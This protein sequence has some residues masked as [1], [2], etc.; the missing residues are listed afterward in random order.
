MDLNRVSA[1]HDRAPWFLE[2]LADVLA[3]TLGRHGHATLLTVHGWNVVQPAIDLGLGCAPGTDPFSVGP[4]AAVSPAFAAVAVRALVGACAGHRIAAT[5]GARYPARAREN[6]LQLFT[7]R[8]AGDGRSRVAALASMASAVDAVQLELGIPLR[9]PGPWR[10]RFVEACR[11]AL[12]SLTAGDG[13]VAGGE[14]ATGRPANALV[15]CRLQFAGVPFSGLA[16]LG[17]DGGA[18]LL[19]LPHDGGLLLFTG[20][21]A[22]GLAVA[23]T[24]PGAV[25]L[26]YA[27]PLLRF[28]DTRPFLDLERG[29]AAGR[30]VD[31]EVRMT[32][33]PAHAGSEAGEFGSVAGTVA[34]DGR[35]VELSATAFAED[36]ER[37]GPWPRLRAALQL[38]RTTALSLTLGLAGQEV[39][40]FLCRAG[41]HVGVTAARASLGPP[42]APLE[43]VTLEVEVA[44]GER[45]CVE[46][47][48]VHELPVVRSRGPAAVRVVF[49]ACAVDGSRMPVGWCE[50][51]GI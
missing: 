22:G 37:P 15:P 12:P 20:E 5:V 36:D 11:R 19:L 41:R 30:I 44:G 27:G 33:T 3:A 39:T 47:S 1:A 29:L 35:H 40:G 48:A 42:A 6:L 16:A 49:A 13:D 25:S 7:R 9:W 43:R 51:G 32:F 2:R 46:V 45:I 50:A 8:Y 18:R 10:T 23:T 26:C 21:R 28:P 34:L 4:D 38:D 31:A 24:G 14:P 17:A